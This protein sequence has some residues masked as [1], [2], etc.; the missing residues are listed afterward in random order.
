MI[1]R[2]SIRRAAFGALILVTAL[3]PFATSAATPAPTK[4]NSNNAKTL[5]VSLPGP[6]NGCTFLDPGANASSNAVLDLIRP[7]A[8][9]TTYSGN[10]YGAGGPIASAELTSLTPEVVRYTIAPHETWSNGA[11]FTGN[12]LTGWWRKARDLASVQSDGY[13]AIRTMVI[14]KDG[15]TV[16]ATF[17]TPY[18]DWN[19]LF[20]DVEALGTASG[21]SL[22]A[23][24]ERPSLGPYR[25]MS[26]TSNRIVLRMNTGWPV[27]IHRFGRVVL[28]NA[29]ALPTLPNAQFVNYSLDVSRA[30]IQALSSHPTVFSHIGASTDIELITFAPD[31]PFSK[32]IAVRRAL[33]WSVERQSL[34]NQLWGAVTFSPSPGAS[35]IYSQG[36]NNY[37]GTSGSAPSSQTTTTTSLVSG[38]TTGL[39]DC[40]SCAISLLGQ[41]GFHRTASGWATAG[42]IPLVLSV[43]VGPSALDDAV[44]TSVVRQWAAIG[45]PVSRVPAPS[46]MA[47]AAEASTSQV[48]L[49]IFARPTNTAASYAARSWSGSGFPDSYPGG[50]RSDAITTLFRK[51][52]ANFNPVSAASTWLTIDKALLNSFWV[53]P[54]F[55]SP[56]LSEW[57]NSLTVVNPSFSIPGLVDQ[58]PG[59]TTITPAAQG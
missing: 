8:F 20:R 28:T 29:G 35:A 39:A 5:I 33:S 36:Q 19:L 1:P 43:A 52:I 21:C 2:G 44:A 22:R 45:I 40:L 58:L 34:I 12:D 25:V 16:T 18:A 30:Q 38:S 13:R 11:P 15:M 51:A 17:S 55:T 23:L 49:A 14:A 59:W 27:N 26:A 42:G 10:P 46:E 32:R 9:L 54:L 48:D 6:F 56:S 7:S 37:P 41:S 4:V 31:R 47:A 3:A 24:V 53:R 50:W 57:S